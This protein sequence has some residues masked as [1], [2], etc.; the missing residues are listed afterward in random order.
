V[1]APAAGVVAAVAVAADNKETK[2][3]AISFWSTTIPT[4]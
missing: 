3:K 2:W 1:G 4:S